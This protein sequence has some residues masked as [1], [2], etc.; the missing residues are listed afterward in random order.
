MKGINVTKETIILNGF[1]ELRKKRH[2]RTKKV[3]VNHPYVSC[4]LVKKYVFEA[5]P[6]LQTSLEV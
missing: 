4:I 3:A 6:M 5:P 2:L 1:K